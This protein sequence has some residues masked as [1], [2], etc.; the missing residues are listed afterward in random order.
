MSQ[1]ASTAATLPFRDRE[2]V[3]VSASGGARE[4]GVIRHAGE[5]STMTIDKGEE[6]A[7]STGHRDD[8]H[9]HVP[10][11]RQRAFKDACG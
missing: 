5:P 10:S 1:T 9:G 4:T 2:N 11:Q 6:H 7:D 8:G 3:A